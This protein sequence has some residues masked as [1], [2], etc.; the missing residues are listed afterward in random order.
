MNRILPLVI[1]ALSAMLA[2]P[3]YANPALAGQLYA[4]NWDRPPA[5][6][7]QRSYRKPAQHHS[8]KARERDRYD[9][10]DVQEIVCAGKVR[11]LGTQWIGTEGA[12]EA[13]KK[14]W[15]ERVRYDLGERFLDL[16]HARDFNSRCGRTSI[17]E[18]MG[19]VMFRCEIIARPCQGV[20]V[21]TNGADK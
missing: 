1:I 10:D 13:A 7:A 9:I 11:G 2:A 4:T 15:M 18:T 20:M 12:M 19:Q 3:V 16:S 14:D 8:S 21:P 5:R 6:H 17:G